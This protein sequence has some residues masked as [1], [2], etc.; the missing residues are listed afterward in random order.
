[1]MVLM[2]NLVQMI[3]LSSMTDGTEIVLKTP[4]IRPANQGTTVKQEDTINNKTEWSRNDCDL[5]IR[6]IDNYLSKED[7]E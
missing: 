2:M 3:F 5:M 6:C 1:M 7:R 4:V